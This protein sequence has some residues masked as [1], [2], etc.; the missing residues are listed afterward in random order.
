M[1]AHPRGASPAGSPRPDPVILRATA[2]L[3]AGALDCHACRLCERRRHVVWDRAHADSRRIR[4]VLVGEGPGDKEDLSG[5]A[6]VGP[7]GDLLDRLLLEA[8]IPLAWVVILN[9]VKCRPPLDA[10]PMEDEVEACTSKWLVPQIEALDPPVIVAFG[11]TASRFFTGMTVTRAR[12]RRHEWRGRIVLPT[13]HPAHLLY[14]RHEK[15]GDD[16]AHALLRE[17]LRAAADLMGILEGV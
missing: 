14:R 1:I 8:G 16:D 5:V 2:D 17:D 4:G 3:R 13:F 9:I 10:T 7:A 15:R 11:S 6:F 12:G